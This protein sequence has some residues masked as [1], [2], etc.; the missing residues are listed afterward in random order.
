MRIKLAII[1]ITFFALLSCENQKENS[2]YSSDHLKIERTSQ[3]TF[4]HISFLTTEDYGK[5]ACNGMI[6][7]DDNEALVFDTP[8]NDKDSRELIDWVKNELNC[9]VV[10]VI[11]THFHND[12]LGGL[13][14]FHERQ[15]ASYASDRT[16]ELAQL[17]GDDIPQNGFDNY[18]EIKVGTKKVHNE[19]FGEGHTL[20][21]IVSYFPSEKVLFGGCLI[22][23][24]NASKGYL[25]DANVNDWS[26]TVQ[27]VKRKYDQ[28]EIII[29]GHGEPGGVEL[30]DY[31]I[32]LFKNE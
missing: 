25:G 11:V 2:I 15:I 17:E 21:N 8:V 23:E 18:L 14:E 12:C 30:L 10:G 29:P 20:D 1:S 19:Y 5:V 26:E 3:N 6:V 28:A 9:E 32:E 7:V 24:V 31:T 13:S 27:S 4:R 22:K 16:I